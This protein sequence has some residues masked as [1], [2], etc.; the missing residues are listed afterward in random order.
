MIVDDSQETL[1]VFEAFLSLEDY[2]VATAC[3]GEECL[4]QIDSFRPDL[5]ILD[6][7][8]PKMNGWEVLDILERRKD[9]DKLRILIFTVKGCFE[10]DMQRIISNPDYHYVRKP[11]SGAELVQKVKGF[12]QDS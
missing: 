12:F 10:D 9:P 6:I 11:V 3:S 4:Q 2:Q 7:M 1:E 5:V 8:M